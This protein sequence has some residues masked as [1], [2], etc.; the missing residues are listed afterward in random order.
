MLLAAAVFA[1]AAL[2]STSATMSLDQ[3]AGTSAGGTHNLGLNLSFTNTGT[4]SPKNLTINLPPGLLA[5]A[6][7][8]GGKCLKTAASSSPL[9]ACKA[10]TGTV[11]AQPDVEVTTL[12]GTSLPAPVSVP[13]S[14]YLVKPPASGDLA[15]LEVYSS[16]LSEQLGS[17]GAVLVRPSG[18]ADGVGATIK[19]T[20]PDTLTL[21]LPVLGKVNA[22]PISIEKIASTFDNLRYPTTCPATPQNLAATVNSYSDAALQSLSKPLTVTGC[23]SLAYSPKFTASVKRDSAD[24]EVAVTTNVTQTAS[25]APSRS[26]QLT[27]PTA[28]LFPNLAS[29][30]QL[31]LTLSSS[32]PLVG[33][34]TAQSPLYPTALTGKAY[35]TGNSSGL[36]LTLVF[37]SP[38]P[39]TLTGTID[40][41][42]DS[43]TFTGL[44]DIPLTSL[45]V[46]LNGGAKGLFLTTC[47]PASGAAKASLVDQNGDKSRTVSSS[48]TVAGCPN[49]S[50]GGGSSSGGGSG[51]GSGSGGT[52][53]TSSGPSASTVGTHLIATKMSGLASGKPS[54]AFRVSVNKHAAMPR[55]L[56]V[57]L[58][59]GL[60]LRHHKVHGTQ[61]VRGV[62]LKGARARSAKLAHGRLVLTLRKSSRKITV[63]LG[64]RSLKE[65][66]AL[67]AKAKG[68]KLTQVRLNV[69][70]VNAKHKRR[71][72]TVTIK[73]LNLG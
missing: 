61:T 31:C 68:R 40:L 66:K 14:F 45:L 13:V 11:T 33:S 39:L 46:K 47:S 51:S 34:V 69:T 44:P 23:S 58:P 32:C 3:S 71:A 5:N 21:T 60:S 50:G 29:V 42:N 30:G 15:G 16:T 38:F 41:L 6:A 54:L 24:P 8:D 17:T 72:M 35:L 7:V 48:F 36:S 18:S 4:D 9:A 57:T 25:Q 12:L 63:K 49:T 10:G 53:V 52:S 59:K 73:K 27:F 37:P 19:L 20:L 67:R 70:V 43:A 22:A 1:P 56:T 2:A 64:P 65:S 26:V 62:T 28:V 55:K